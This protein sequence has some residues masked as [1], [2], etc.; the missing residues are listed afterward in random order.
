[1]PDTRVVATLTKRCVY[2][3]TYVCSAWR[4]L[5]YMQIMW[6]FYGYYIA[7]HTYVGPCLHYNA[8][9]SA[10]T[11]A[12]KSL[13]GITI[14]KIIHQSPRH[15]TDP[16]K[17]CDKSSSALS[18]I[19]QVHIFQRQA[20]PCVRQGLTKAQKALRIPPETQ[21]INPP[22]H[23]PPIFAIVCNDYLQLRPSTRATPVS[24]HTHS[25]LTLLTIKR[26]SQ[27]PYQ[28]NISPARALLKAYHQRYEMGL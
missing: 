4:M 1:M 11:K 20:D 21:D 7:L 5:L 19:L 13:L 28:M 17:P 6:I 14:E 3:S 27:W 24:P 25:L 8:V 2:T 9:P 22:R 26:E 23:T 15:T 18:V 12:I 10:W 16:H